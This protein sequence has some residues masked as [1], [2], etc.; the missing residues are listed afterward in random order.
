MNSQTDR[1][2]KDELE[3]KM[4]IDSWIAR[5]LRFEYRGGF[6]YGVENTQA[7]MDFYRL[8]YRGRYTV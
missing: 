3:I 6:F 5:M 1:K 2:V 7:F 8:H 4:S